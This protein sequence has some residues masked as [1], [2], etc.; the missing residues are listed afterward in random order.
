[1]QQFDTEE[2]ELAYSNI[3]TLPLNLTPATIT[4]TPSSVPTG[5]GVQLFLLM[6]SFYQEVNGAQYSLKNEEFNFKV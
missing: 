3:V 6:I 5:T 4:L 1:M 2:S